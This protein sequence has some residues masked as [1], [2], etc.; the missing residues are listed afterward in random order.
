MHSNNQIFQIE[1]HD[2]DDQLIFHGKTSFDLNFL[3]GIQGWKISSDYLFTFCRILSAEIAIIIDTYIIVEKILPADSRDSSN[4]RIWKDES[5]AGSLAD[6][7]RRHWIRKNGTC[8]SIIAN[9]RSI[10]RP[11]K[12][13]VRHGCP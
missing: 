3:I 11:R 10:L 1:C 13:L 9:R 6:L 12:T 2:S 8:P 4:C 5:Y 7:D